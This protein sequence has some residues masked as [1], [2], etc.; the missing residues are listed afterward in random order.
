MNILKNKRVWLIL[1]ILLVVSIVVLLKSS[2][3]TTTTN[4][5]IPT[6]VTMDAYPIP[7]IPPITSQKQQTA[8]TMAFTPINAPTSLPIYSVLEKDA[9]SV[10][11]TLANQLLKG[12]SLSSIG[13]IN[14]WKSG[15]GSVSSQNAPPG[16]SYTNTTNPTGSLPLGPVATIV[17]TKFLSSLH[18]LPNDFVAIPKNA[19]GFNTE[20]THPD[21]GSTLSANAMQ[22]SFAI[23]MSGFPVI[24]SNGGDL[25]AMVSVGKGD[26]IVDMFS[27][28]VP[29]ITPRGQSDLIPFEQ[30][31][32]ALNNNKG[33][34]TSADK[35]IYS[36]GAS[37]EKPDIK[38]ATITG[39]ELNYFWDTKLSTMYPIYKFT[40]VS[41]DP[42]TKESIFLTYFV[43][44]LQ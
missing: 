37:I 22:V 20:E 33:V 34:L 4:P 10:G 24:D 1:T 9:L 26:T 36:V 42:N 29:N 23:T 41:V 14:Y 21:E 35:A 8:F 5:V 28:L 25:H 30:A 18:T 6:D 3:K 2:P 31:V 16:I 40:G 7:P 15:T 38:T 19:T 12:S 44:A 17:A 11:Q 32:L 39:A 13:G 43:S 27:S